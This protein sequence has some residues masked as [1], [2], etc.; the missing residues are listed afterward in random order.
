MKANLIT[1]RLLETIKDH[2]ITF[3]TQRKLFKKNK[4]NVTNW[5]KDISRIEYA[6]KYFSIISLCIAPI[7]IVIEYFFLELIGLKQSDANRET[8][9]C[10]F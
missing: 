7:A 3:Y 5:K 1:S 2:F 4:N 8:C 10:E 6:F 9:T